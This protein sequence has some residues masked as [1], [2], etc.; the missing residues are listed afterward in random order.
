MAQARNTFS[1]QTFEIFGNEARAR[2]AIAFI[3]DPEV[4]VSARQI[5]DAIDRPVTSIMDA[6]YS[7]SHLGL[8]ELVVNESVAVK[9]FRRTESPL[10]PIFDATKAVLD[11]MGV[12]VFSIASNHQVVE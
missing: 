8:L 1:N 6:L 7:L 12:Q 10:W 5:A 3:P 2:V 4:N 11:E 9:Q